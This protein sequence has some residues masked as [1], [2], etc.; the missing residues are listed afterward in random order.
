[1]GQTNRTGWKHILCGS[2]GSEVAEA[3]LVLPLM[4]TMLLGVFWVGR[5]Y[6]IYAVMNHAAR[7]GARAGGS[8]DCAACVN[9]VMSADQ[10][11]TNYVAPLLRA[12]GLDPNL[13]TYTTP[14]YCACGSA[15]CGTPVACDSAGTGAVPSICVQH[16]VDLGAPNYLPQ[17]C[18]TA[19]SFEY[20]FHLPLPFAP[21]SV[22]TVTIKTQAQAR[23][24]K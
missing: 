19:V 16:D 8:S 9:Q 6:N 5:A 3:A 15:T 14:N 13:V 2:Y 22:Q 21:A 11:A 10:V 23:S 4:F 7:E 24:E 20:P 12:S 17:V 18:G 1:M